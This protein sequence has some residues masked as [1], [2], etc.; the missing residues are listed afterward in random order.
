MTTILTETGWEDPAKN[1]FVTWTNQTDRVAQ[2][3][4]IRVA[5]DVITNTLKEDDHMIS[6]TQFTINGGTIET[7]KGRDFFIGSAKINDLENQQLQVLSEEKLKLQAL[8][9]LLKEELERVMR[10]INSTI[11]D[12]GK[13]LQ[14]QSLSKEELKLQAE[15]LKLQTLL[16]ILRKGTGAESTV[17]DRALLRLITK[18]KDR[19]E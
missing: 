17:N 8:L 10:E 16:K 14:L 15:E 5:N 1:P 9:A 13:H 11:I 4:E 12:A 3:N 7:G 2:V 6:G 19:S 18:P